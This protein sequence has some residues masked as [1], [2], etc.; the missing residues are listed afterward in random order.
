MGDIRIGT[1]SWTDKTLL[2]SGWYPEDVVDDPGARL[3]YY[4]ER[5]PLVEVDSTYYWPPGENTAKTWVDRTPRDFT[6][7]IKAYSLLTKHP[8]KTSSL[9]KDLRPGTDKRNVYIDDLEPK[10]VDEVW[11]RFLGALDPLDRQDKLGGLLFQ[12]PPWFVI[13]KAN[14]NYILECAKRAAPVPIWVELRHKSWMSGDNVEE[15]LDFLEGH[16]LSYV[17]VDMPQGFKS[18]LPPIA[19]AT[20]EHAVIRFHGRNAEQWESGDVHKRF[21]YD[22]SRKELEEWVPKIQEVAAKANRTHVLLN[23]CY[24][25]Y[26]QNNAKELARLLS[27]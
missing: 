24:R 6:F 27:T 19:V 3:K 10:V 13:S 20:S 14:K 17:C 26:A 15:T 23:N 2:A 16:G 18:S 25:D 7:D 1:C 9:Y 12:F 11:D 8:T 5:F 22:Y 21:A 4:A